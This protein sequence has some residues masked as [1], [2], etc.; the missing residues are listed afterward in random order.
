MLFANII[1]VIG[2]FIDKVLGIV[3]KSIEDKT[4]SVKLKTELINEAIKFDSDIET[5]KTEIITTE[6]KGENVLQKSWRP[7][8][9][10]VIIAII[11]NNYLFAP[12]VQ[13]F[14]G[15]SVMLN[16]PPELYSLLTIGVG[17][18]IMGRSGE[19]IMDRYNNGKN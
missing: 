7:I 4:L 16:L 5:R 8:L 19:K 11:A 14:W 15:R 18:Y 3:D 6:M 1:P 2:P 10:L 9:M 13:I 12:Y 17:G